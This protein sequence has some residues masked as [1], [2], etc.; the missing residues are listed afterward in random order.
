[1]AQDQ[2][3]KMTKT[4]VEH[5]VLSLCGP[6]I[7]SMLVT[8][9]YNL[10]D[11]YFVNQLGASYGGA[12]GI[13]FSLMA[14]IQ[15]IGFML[16][17]G[18]SSL[19]AR[20]LGQKKPEEAS[21]FASTGFFLALAGG[22]LLGVAGLVFLSPLM[23]LLG[24]TPT[25]LPHA[26]AYGACILLAAPF[27][28]ASCVLNNLLRYEG[29][30]FL[31]MWGLG[32]GAILN[33]GI[34][35]AGL[36][37][38]LSQCISFGI[39]LSMFLRGC[40]QCRLS[41]V[42]IWHQPGQILRILKNGT[43]SLA[44]QGLNSLSVMLINHQAALFGDAA[45][46]AFSIVGRICNFL[47]SLMIGIGQGLQPVASFNYGAKQYG[48]VRRA[49]LFTFLFSEA[50]LGCLSLGCLLGGTQILRC[51]SSEEQVLQVAEIPFRLQSIT[52]LLQPLVAC[53]N[54]LFQSIGLSGRATLLASLR[55]G[56]LLIPSYPLLTHIWEI[57]GLQVAQACSDVASF[58]ITLPLLIP[59]LAYL[60]K[61][62]KI[63]Q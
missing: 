62:D 52:L 36:A 55:S 14:L 8:N 16:G 56:L 60:Q 58:L 32:T 3:E 18:S 29:K 51:F 19:V 24:S 13:V 26:Q 7:V 31:A 53:A 50:A 44:R 27:M 43:P 34:Q 15:A 5:L 21:R 4:P 38:A 37:T 22:G 33:M 35:G 59:F 17:H 46:A 49:F 40:T 10:A 23:R 57:R 1:M 47:A 42:L 9:L 54:M 2:Y 12:I 30:A 39:L 45:V 25:I 11:T 63:G 28:T 41:P 61:Q 6:T 48:R 20:L